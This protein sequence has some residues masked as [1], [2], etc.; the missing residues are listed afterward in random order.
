ML[1]SSEN[2]GMLIKGLCIHISCRGD[3]LSNVHL[4]FASSE[5]AVEFCEKNGKNL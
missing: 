1:F 4:E 5:A 3:P 2:Y